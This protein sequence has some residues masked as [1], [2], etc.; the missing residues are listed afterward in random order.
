MTEMNTAF[1]DFIDGCLLEDDA[2]CTYLNQEL[3][4]VLENL[5]LVNQEEWEAFQNLAA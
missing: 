3:D 4:E 1:D 5:L 2:L